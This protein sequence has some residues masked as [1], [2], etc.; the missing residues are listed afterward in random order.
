MSYRFLLFWVNLDV[1]TA[2]VDLTTPQ[3]ARLVFRRFIRV[4]S[5]QTKAELQTSQ[6]A[7]ACCAFDGQNASENWQLGKK[8]KN[9]CEAPTGDNERK[10]QGKEH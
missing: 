6:I 5:G 9:L 1:K 2:G 7:S 8:K 3:H 4:R 10:Q